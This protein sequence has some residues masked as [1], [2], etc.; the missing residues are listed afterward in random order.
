MI[1]GADFFTT[2]VWTGIGLVTHYVLFVIGHS[3]RAVQIAG[4]TTSP[5]AAFMDQVARN[6]TDREDGFLRTMHSTAGWRRG[7]VHGP[8]GSQHER[9]R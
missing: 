3:T 4:V 2:E 5:D 7:R 1:A 6:L 8:P 9:L